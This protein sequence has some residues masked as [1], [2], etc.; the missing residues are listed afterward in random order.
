MV[1]VWYNLSLLELSL[2]LFGDRKHLDWIVLLPDLLL[3]HL[4]H[5]LIEI[6]LVRVRTTIEILNVFLLRSSYA[7]SNSIHISFNYS[8]GWYQTDQFIV[9]NSIL[10]L[11]LVVPLL[12]RLL[13]SEDFF[14]SE[15]EYV[16]KAPTQFRT[17]TGKCL[18]KL[19][20]SLEPDFWYWFEC[21][22]IWLFGIFLVK[23]L[24]IFF[25]G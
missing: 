20:D 4:S 21:E 2:E 12:S 11:L 25:P 6:W 24:Q 18:F 9:I 14:G 23:F 5:H 8:S 10:I 15:T 1:L 16:S 22:Q 7:L 17:F 13:Q 19:V 3:L